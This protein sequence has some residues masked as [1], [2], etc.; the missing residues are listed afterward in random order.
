MCADQ[1]PVQEQVVQ[2]ASE[3]AAS[4]CKLASNI[5]H[6]ATAKRRKTEHVTTSGGDA[7]GGEWSSGAPEPASK[8]KGQ[9]EMEL[10]DLRATALLVENVKARAISLA[11][12]KRRADGSAK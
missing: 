5:L 3:Q 8:R 12:N 9:A 2:E 6:T 11:G 1:R 4:H 10:E 7:G